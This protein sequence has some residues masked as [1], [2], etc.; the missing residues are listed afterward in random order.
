MV[1]A[2]CFAYDLFLSGTD[3]A[4]AQYGERYTIGLEHIIKN[5]SAATVK[6]FYQRWYRPEHMAVFCMGDFDDPDG[7]VEEVQKAFGLLQGSN[8]QQLQPIPR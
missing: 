4:C 6:G 2:V 1:V 5:V 3:A 8:E 7:L